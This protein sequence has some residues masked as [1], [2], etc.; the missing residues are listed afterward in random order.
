MACEDFQSLPT[1]L[2]TSKSIPNL[3]FATSLVSK[4]GQTSNLSLKSVENASNSKT[5]NGK[6][7]AIKY[8]DYL[9]RRKALSYRFKVLVYRLFDSTIHLDRSKFLSKS[10][11][12][13]FDAVLSFRALYLLE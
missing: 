11:V 1:I 3:P 8:R 10:N 5:L 13:F 2:T 9:Q 7:S 12:S 4:I 6:P